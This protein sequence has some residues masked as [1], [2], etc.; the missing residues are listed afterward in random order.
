MTLVLYHYFEAELGSFRN[1]SSLPLEEAHEVLGRIVQDG[2]TF[3][4]QRAG[5]YMETR[6]K[7]EVR[8]RESFIAKGGQP[9]NP[10]PHYM[11]LG[12][13]DWLRSWYVEPN[14]VQIGWDEFDD[15]S[16]SFTYGDLFPTMRYEDGK[17]YRKQVYTK[18]EIREVIARYGFPQEWNKHGDRGPE[19][20]IEAQI[21]DEKV[22]GSYHPS[23]KGGL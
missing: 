16:I 18:D 12:P 4:S 5:D 20:Y 10:Y 3:A 19:R 6:L 21:W 13:C 23:I 17:P 14:V 8:A 22:I 1:L 11:T 2:K 15:R 9:A 7:L